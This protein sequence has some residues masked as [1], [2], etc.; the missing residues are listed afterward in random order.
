MLERDEKRKIQEHLD[1]VLETIRQNAHANNQKGMKSSDLISRVTALTVNKIAPQSKMLLSSAYNMMMSRT[2]AEPYFSDSQKKSEFYEMD[3]LS[4]IKSKF[5]FSIPS[6]IDYQKDQSTV[7]ALTASGAVV[8][9]GGIVSITMSS[10][11]PIG[12]AAILAG[13][14]A[15]VIK[16]K[17]T[18]SN[19][20]IEEIINEYLQNVSQSFMLWLESIESFYDDKVTELKNRG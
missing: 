19:A 4:Q 14:M 16:S 2:L 11:V 20:D 17:S 1:K 3:I 12:I 7:K 10:W 18:G 13:I 9:V 5:D 15:Y 8:V 6:E